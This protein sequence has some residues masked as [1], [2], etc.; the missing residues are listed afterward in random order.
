V[1]PWQSQDGRTW[2]TRGEA[3]VERELRRER[4]SGTDHYVLGQYYAEEVEPDD[5]REGGPHEGEPRVALLSYVTRF[6]VV[7]VPMIRKEEEDWKP[8]AP[9]CRIA[10]LEVDYGLRPLPDDWELNDE[11]KKALEG[12][13]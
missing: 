3:L 4:R 5:D 7:V 6:G 8:L 13:A 11:M 9:A 10:G 12:L 1:A 2:E